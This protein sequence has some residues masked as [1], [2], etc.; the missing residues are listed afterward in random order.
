MTS[1]RSA[2]DERLGRILRAGLVGAEPVGGEFLAP[3]SGLA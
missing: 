2:T 3:A 1:D